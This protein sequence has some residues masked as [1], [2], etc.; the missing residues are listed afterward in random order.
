MSGKLKSAKRLSER[1]RG[2]RI[3]LAA[4]RAFA[5]AIAEGFHPE[6]IILFGSHAYG[7][8]H[9]ESD[10]DIL[11]VTRAGSPIGQATRIRL[12][13]PRRFPMDLLV[14]TPDEIRKRLVAGD[15][16]LRDH[17]TGQNTL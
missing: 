4:I 6:Q 16:F 13:V 3:A 10:V 7:K 17:L 11:V 1:P 5:H 14:R 8:P 12:A 15:W 9:T 2:P